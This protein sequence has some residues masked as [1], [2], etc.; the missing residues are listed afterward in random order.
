MNKDHANMSI[1]P[2]YNTYSVGKT[3]FWDSALA[4][5]GVDLPP[6]V[7][8]TGNGLSGEF[9]VHGGMFLAEGIPLTPFHSGGKVTI[10]AASARPSD[11][12]LFVFDARGRTVRLLHGESA[13]DGQGRNVSSGMYFLRWDE[14]NRSIGGKLVVVN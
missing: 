6:N 13:A 8:L 12:R 10:M 5:F 9:T 14:G 4:L 3:D 1:L 7:G 11:G 2:P